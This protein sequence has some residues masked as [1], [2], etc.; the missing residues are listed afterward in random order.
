ME[1]RYIDH[2]V[3]TTA[4]LK[5]CLGFYVGVLGMR[6]TEENGRYSLFF[7]NC[8]INIHSRK[9]EFLPAA[10]HP[11]YG[12]QDFCLIVDDVQAAKDELTEKGCP[13]VEGI[14]PRSGAKGNMH[15]IYVRDPDGNL[16]ELSEYT[17]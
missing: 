3:I 8:K 9:G 6:C 10:E 17:S 14:V 13:I 2:L 1:I 11:E 16:V 12:A 7:G 15:S 5:Q 4:D